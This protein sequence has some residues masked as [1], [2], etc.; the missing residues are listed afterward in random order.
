MQSINFEFLRSRWPELAA[1]GGF[2]ESYAHGDPIGALVKL[3]AY[4]EQMVAFLYH[5]HR[6]PKAI[7]PPLVELLDGDAFKHAIPRVIVTKFHSLRIDGNRAAHGNQGDTTT[8]LRLLKDAHDLARWLHLTYAGGAAADCPAFAEPPFGGL[9][10]SQRRREKR[11]ILERVA[12]QEA[13]MQRLLADLEATR[14]QTQQAEATAAELKAEVAIARAAAERSVAALAAVNPLD[15]DEAAT[16]RQLIDRMLAD[17]GWPVPPG[18]SSN[19]RVGKEVRVEHQATDSGIGYAD[20]VLFDEAGKPLAVIEAK[21]TVEDPE[22]GR[23]QAQG[24]ADGLEEMHD[25]RPIIFYTNGYDLWICNDLQQEPPRK[26]YGFYSP[27]SLQYRHFQ[28][29]HGEPLAKAAPNPN[30]AGRMYQ[31]EAV[32]RV[33]ERFAEKKRE[34]LIVQATG[35][36]KTRVAVSL[37]DALIRA[38]QARRIL[39]LCDRRELRKQANNAFKEFLPSEPR[40]IVAADTA[41]DRDKRIYLATYPAMMK[42]YEKFDVGFFDLI[43]ADESHRSIYNRYR[44]LFYYFDALKVGLT[45]TPIKYRD[46]VRNTFKLFKCEDDDPTF[47]FDY[48]DAIGHHPPFLTPF[49]VETVTTE[50]LREGIKYSK[51][52]KEQREQLDGE[53]PDPASIEH[54][55]EEVDKRIFNKD[56]NRIILRNLMDHGI[57]DATA[58]RVGKSIIFARN[59]NHAMLLQRLFEDMY[60]QYGGDFC[61]VID[62]YDPRAEDLIADFKGDGRNRELTIA[63]SV[64]MLDTGID[65]PEIVNLVFAKPVYAPVKFWQMIGRGTRLCPDLFG[66]GKDKTHFLIFD[67]WGNFDRFDEKY[68]PA[69]TAPVKSLM[70]LVFESRLALAEAA[71]AAQNNAAFD[72]AASLIKKDLAALPERTVAVREKWRD[73]N[74]VARPEVLKRFD[75]ATRAVLLH[76]VAPLMQ[77]VNIAGHEEAYKFDNVVCKL[78]AERLKGSSKFEDLRAEVVDAVSQLP[79][80]LSQV[81]VKVPA[82]DRISRWATGRASAPR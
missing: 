42:C 19:D 69:E 66:P 58:S 49:E 40:T 51:M 53:E 50:F 14:A 33:V 71:L 12:A 26:L 15:F 64:D 52:T 2:A 41:D 54:D 18:L 5:H 10:E 23:T 6:L 21:K 72:L 29:R 30:I 65:V 78:Q 70:Q 55:R 79:I 24:Y 4:A 17:A 74:T 27:D 20:Y 45:A 37:S 8:A 25:Q 68:T 7:R 35:T 1:L 62:N 44:E 22:K 38:K 60:P 28:S 81:A 59:H 73:I 39:F 75:A 80:N 32:R 11:A 47:N 9:A 76:Q 31:M 43:I 56:T 61:R 3:R 36:G 63:I 67:H 48:V 77:W 13:E 16:R 82:I 46:M 34:A 57:R